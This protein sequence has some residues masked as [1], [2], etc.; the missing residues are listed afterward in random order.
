M[1]AARCRR[2]PAG[3]LAGLPCFSGESSALQG[4]SQLPQH[5]HWLWGSAVRSG[6]QGPASSSSARHTL[7]TLRGAR[8]EQGCSHGALAS[9]IVPTD[10]CSC[11]RTSGQ[12]RAP[13]ARNPPPIIVSSILRLV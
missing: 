10:S 11:L 4:T 6:V 2:R 9:G 3:R 7:G 5:P 8:G 13:D 1:M 12:G